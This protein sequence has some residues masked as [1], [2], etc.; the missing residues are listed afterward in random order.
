MADSSTTVLDG[1]WKAASITLEVVVDGVCTNGLY[2]ATVVLADFA[3]VL[4][5]VGMAGRIWEVYIR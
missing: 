2:R 5:E 1:I 3:S 4:N